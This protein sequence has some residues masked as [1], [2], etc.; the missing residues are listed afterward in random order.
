MFYSI[1]IPVYNRP[2]ELDELLES[3][4]YQYYSDFEVLVI[5]DGSEPPCKQIA[6]NYSS[7]LDI[8]YFYKENSGQ[9]F[10]RNYGFERA[11]GDYFVVFD[12]DCLIPEQYL[13]IVDSYIQKHKIDCWG[14]PDRAH[15][16]FSA[17]QKAI[18]VSMTSLFTTGG[19]RGEKRQAGSYLP[20][21]FNMGISREVFNKTGGYIIT[22]M[23]EDLEF[24]VRIQKLGFKTALIPDAFVYHKRR[25]NL[26]DFFKQLHFFGRARINLKK[27]HPEQVEPVHYL[28]TIFLLGL[29]VSIAL[30][31]LNIPYLNYS[32]LLYILY[33]TAL[34]IES[35]SRE[36]SVKISMIAVSAA[37]IQLTAYS[38]GFM[39]EWMGLGRE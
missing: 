1:I 8:R 21:S 20:R 12:S 34:F 9:G 4:T 14:G 26:L 2:D 28:P 10:S 30:L 17:M 25:T 35:M 33:A 5:D 7:K 24:S 3:L 36:K 19:I 22:R 18:N 11:R 29:I 13:Q 15:S 32:I 37:F 31:V 27:F 6:E 39:S 16:D 38:V 23:A